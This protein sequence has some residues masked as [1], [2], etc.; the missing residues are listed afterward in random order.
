MYSTDEETN[1]QVEVCVQVISLGRTTE[2]VE[3]ILNTNDGTSSGI[4]L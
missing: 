4:Y 2:D 1:E 3:V